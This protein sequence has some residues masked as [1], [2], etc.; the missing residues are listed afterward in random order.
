MKD[1][2]KLSKLL[3]PCLETDEF[4]KQLQSEGITDRILLRHICRK[5][6]LA[7]C[8]AVDP[9]YQATRFHSLLANKLQGVIERVE[10]NEDVRLLV[11]VPPR[12]GKSALISTLL[13]AWTLGRNPWPVMCASY[14][15]TL[16]E[17]FSQK[18]RDIVS[19][20]T[21]RIIFPLSRPNPD[22]TSKELWKTLN[23]G[24]YRAAGITG[25]LTGLGGKLLL[26]I[27][28]NQTI[29]T[30]K[31]YIPIRDIVRSESDVSVWAYN[32][33]S[34]QTELCKIEEYITNPGGVDLLE[35]VLE[36]GHKFRCTE[37]HPIYVVGKGYIPANEVTP[38]DKLLVLE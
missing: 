20:K 16:A 36:D 35:F 24:Q 10:R 38:V 11:E 18:C 27:P 33:I 23:G 19:S 15:S 32:E 13:P 9:K 21:Y 26:C 34:G 17:E 25:P 8:L 5:Y 29:A 28:G 14:G 31:G 7:F 3:R 37:D 4:L 12:H 6:F 1:L 22:S 2:E 30:D